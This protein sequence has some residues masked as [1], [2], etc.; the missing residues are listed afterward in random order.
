MIAACVKTWW[1]TQILYQQFFS[2]LTCW[3]AK[4]DTQHVWHSLDSFIFLYGCLLLISGKL[5]MSLCPYTI[6][7]LIGSVIRIFVF[8]RTRLTLN[9]PIWL[10]R[11]KTIL[12][13]A[14]KLHNF[15]SLI[16]Q[17]VTICSKTIT[18]TSEKLRNLRVKTHS[19]KNIAFGT[20]A[21]PSSQPFW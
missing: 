20:S 8:R 9:I 12:E 18:A 4:S 13:L 11:E 21:S 19:T 14:V 17:L 7:I 5:L 2:Y 6:I 3:W 1:C 10:I 15:L 16:L